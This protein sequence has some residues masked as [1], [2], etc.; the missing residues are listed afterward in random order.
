MVRTETCLHYLSGADS[1]GLSLLL[2]VGVF[3][4]QRQITES[5]SDFWVLGSVGFLV[6]LQCP[7]IKGSDSCSPKGPNGLLVTHLNP[8]EPTKSK[9]FESRSLPQH[10]YPSPPEGRQSGSST[11]APPPSQRSRGRPRA[12]RSVSELRR[13]SKPA[14]V[15]EPQTASADEVM[16]RRVR[17][18]PADDRLGR[19]PFEPRRRAPNSTE[20]LP[21]QNI[22]PRRVRCLRRTRRPSRWRYR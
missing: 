11:P 22:H 14:D 13:E 3:E 2:S 5:G 1:K 20:L 16:I 17:A 4:E 7:F 18:P 9:N 15:V 12:E 21:T 6:D 8:S 10:F 19:P